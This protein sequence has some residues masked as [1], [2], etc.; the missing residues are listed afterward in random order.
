MLGQIGGVAGVE[1]FSAAFF[2]HFRINFLVDAGSITR[3]ARKFLGISTVAPNTY[4][5]L[6]SMTTAGPT[7][8]I[9]HFYN[10]FSVFL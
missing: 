5:K 10:P 4:N 1:N 6:L 3:A 7:V 8:D 9:T 2:A